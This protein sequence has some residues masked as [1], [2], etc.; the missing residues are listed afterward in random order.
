MTTFRTTRRIRAGGWF[1]LALCLGLTCASIASWKNRSTAQAS[2]FD[3]PVGFAESSTDQN[4][5][6][7]FRIVADGVVEDGATGIRRNVPNIKMGRAG[8]EALATLDLGTKTIDERP[9]LRRGEGP[10]PIR[11]RVVSIGVDSDVVP[12]GIDQNRALVVPKRSDIAGWWSGGSAPG[13]K[14][15]TVIVGH[16]DSKI[17]AGVFEHLKDTK[18]G[19]RILVERSDRSVFAYEVTLVQRLSKTSFPT[20]SVY[21][22]TSSSTLR[23]VT[24]G[25]K[26][27]RSTGHYVDN[28]IV[29]AE[30][31]SVDETGAGDDPEKISPFI[32]VGT[33]TS[34]TTTSSTT[35]TST[36]SSTTSTT[37]TSISTTSSASPTPIRPTTIAPTSTPAETKPNSASTGVPAIGPTDATTTTSPSGLSSPSSPDSTVPPTSPAATTSTPPTASEPTGSASA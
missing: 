27:D 30:L 32:G 11:L 16:Y 18:E 17:S 28:T 26:F 36:T 33:S 25:G 37:T 5:P 35:S 13:E 12:I 20:Q 10:R 4:S 14:G 29:Y 21:G 6:G 7:R 34:T 31:V 19:A 23:L 3:A 2:G 9:D 22:P 24:C 8:E 1:S 15:P